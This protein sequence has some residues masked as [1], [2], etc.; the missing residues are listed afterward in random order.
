MERH[1]QGRWVPATGPASGG[2]RVLAVSVP[3][4]AAASSHYATAGSEYAPRLVTLDE[5]FAG[6]DDDFRAKCLGLLHALDLDVVM[7][8]ER[9][10]ACYTQVPGVAI[11][12]LSRVEELDAVLVTRWERDGHRRVRGETPPRPWNAVREPGRRLSSG[13]GAQPG[14]SAPGLPP[15]P[16]LRCRPHSAPFTPQAEPLSTTTVTSTGGWPAYRH[17]PAPQR[18]VATVALNSR[19]LPHGRSPHV[20]DTPARRRPADSPWYPPLSV[21]LAELGARIE[22]EAVL[23]DLL[24]DLAPRPGH[25]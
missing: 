19:R 3:L 8:S 6:V 9:E 7:T 20:P 17:H 22:K 25:R 16:A 4:F 23:D 15:W 18:P 10:W 21:A 13:R 14:L 5:A 2:E 11:A 12:Q 1:Q 24:T